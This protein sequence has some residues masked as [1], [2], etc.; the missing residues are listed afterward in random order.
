MRR[1]DSSPWALIAQVVVHR[2]MMSIFCSLNL[3]A[4]RTISSRRENT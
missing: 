1:D 3:S 2:H 4:Q